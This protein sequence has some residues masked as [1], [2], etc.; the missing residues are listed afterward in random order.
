M[1][2]LN[3]LWVHFECPKCNYIDE[4][5][6]VDAKTEKQVYCHNCKID[7]QLRDHEAS[8]HN[9]IESINKAFKDI[10]NLFKNFGK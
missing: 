10:E 2:N 1:T 8:V 6:L 4:I 5:Q 9:G 3:Y 7:I